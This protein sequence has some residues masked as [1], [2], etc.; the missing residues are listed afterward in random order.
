MDFLSNLTNLYS[1]IKNENPYASFFTGDFNGHLLCWW[2][3]GDTMAEGREIENLLSSRSHSQLISEPTSFVPNKTPSC[4]DLVITDQAKLVI[5]SGTR[6]SLDSF[7][8][9]QI[10]YYK[11]NVNIPPY[12]HSERN[13]WYYHRANTTLLKRSMY[14]FPWLQHLNYKPGSYWQ[15]KTFTNF[16]LTDFIPNVIKRIVPR[17]SPW[18]TKPLQTLL[19][20]KN[21]LF[22][23]YKRHRYKPEYKVR[24]DNFRKFCQEAVEIAKLNYLT[25]IGKQIK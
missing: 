12:P 5:D 22:K 6:T 19:N 14:S 15:V 3:D 17:D 8:H 1:K 16:I 13:I 7:C 20:M 23:N 11:V 10:T 24:L 18:K 2:S 9:H 25:N 4:I 21:R